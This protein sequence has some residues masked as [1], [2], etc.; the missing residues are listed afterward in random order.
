MIYMFMN[1]GEIIL[2]TDKSFYLLEFF[3][4]TVLAFYS[5]INFDLNLK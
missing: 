3:P 2:A 5:H 1:M 4:Y